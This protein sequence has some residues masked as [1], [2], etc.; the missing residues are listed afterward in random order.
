MGCSCLLYR[1]LVIMLICMHLQK[2]LAGKQHQERLAEDP[3]GIGRSAQQLADPGRQHAKH[4]RKAEAALDLAARP[5]QGA[6]AAQP[7]VLS[8]LRLFGICKS[9]QHACM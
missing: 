5:I 1:Q 8:A 6:F 9:S 3:K 4:K 7:D 2:Q